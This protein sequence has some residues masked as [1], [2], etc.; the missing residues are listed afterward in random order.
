MNLLT[1]FGVIILSGFLLAIVADAKSRKPEVR[2]RPKQVK[3]KSCTK[4]VC[5][6]AD[7]YENDDDDTEFVRGKGKGKGNGNGKGRRHNH[8]NNPEEKNQ[9]PSLEEGDILPS[10]KRDGRGRFRRNAMAIDPYDDRWTGGKVPYIIRPE[11]T[12]EDKKVIQAAM[13]HIEMKT[14]TDATKCIEFVQ[15]TTE[16]SYLEIKK[17][18]GCSSYVGNYW[19]LDAQ[20]VNLDTYCIKYGPG[21]A[22]HEMLH[23]LGFHHEHM[24]TDRDNY[25]TINFDNVNPERVK[26][27]E[28]LADS[29]NYEPYDYASILH[30]SSDAFSKQLASGHTIEAKDS[31]KTDL[32]GQRLALSNKDIREIQKLYGCPVT[33]AVDP[34]VVDSFCTN[35]ESDTLCTFV[36]LN[37]ECWTALP[38]TDDTR[39]DY[40]MTLWDYFKGT[41]L[42]M[43]P[44][45]LKPGTV[46]RF[47]MNGV[48]A[49]TYCFA[50]NYYMFGANGKLEV[51]VISSTGRELT[52]HTI[53]GPLPEDTWYFKYVT[54]L[55]ADT[56]SVGLKGTMGT[57]GKMLI[58]DINL[59][60][61]PESGFC[62]DFMLDKRRR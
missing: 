20:P 16:I 59:F 26:N 60:T 22:V 10:I 30:Y 51:Y 9:D 21:V 1:V 4:S 11:F 52:V 54:L 31:S 13:E 44:S 2:P 14:Q 58:D 56:F 55:Q 57:V 5:V 23:A 24:R 17:E 32:I 36:N 3:L 40:E 28:K 33:P 42:Q 12:D 53:Q 39:P 7:A 19:F 45:K 61:M 29:H 27:F 37:E 62:D 48:P 34:P 38:I 49:N 35:E 15:R 50:I 25:V 43:D 46:G 18:A 41:A 8:S 6:D 47:Q